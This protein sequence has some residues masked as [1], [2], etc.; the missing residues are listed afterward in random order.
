LGGLKGEEV[1][2]ELRKG[3]RRRLWTFLVVW[4]VGAVIVRTVVSLTTHIGFF[5]PVAWLGPAVGIA[6]GAFLL[7][8]QPR[9]ARR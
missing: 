7:L 1:R 4:I 3:S 8:F 9:Q 2:L 5:D 6:F